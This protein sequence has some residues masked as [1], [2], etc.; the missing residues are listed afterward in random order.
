MFYAAILLCLNL[1]WADRVAKPAQPTLLVDK[2]NRPLPDDP[3]SPEVGWRKILP[4][5]AKTW[6]SV[7]QLVADGS[8]RCT[9]TVIKPPGCKDPS[10]QKA[11]VITNGHCTARAREGFKVKF[12]VIDGLP[13]SHQSE[14]AARP[15]YSTQNHFDL[16]VLELDQDY[17]SLAQFGVSATEIAPSLK[18]GEKVANVAIPL[19]QLP[20]NQQIMRINESCVPD[21]PVTIIDRFRFFDHQVTLKS[22]SLTGGSSGSGLFNTSGQLAGLANAGVINDVPNNSSH[23]CELDT[24]VYDGKSTPKRQMSNFGFDITFLHKC[25]KDC[26]LDTTLPDCPLPDPGRDLG[27][28]GF[29]NANWSSDLNKKVNI[30]SKLFKNYQVKG[31]LPATNCSCKDPSGYQVM[32]EESGKKDMNGS[33]QT[34]LIPSQYFPKETKLTAKAGE[35]P[36]FQFLCLRGQLPNGSWDQLK[37]ATAFP[38]Y[39]YQKKPFSLFK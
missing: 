27:T 20:A 15:L 12:G 30:T 6:S 39:L 24:C 36:T 13:A 17:D 21:K 7:G 10:K 2:E 38:I 37:N 32:K 29:D 5:E 14:I 4:S 18:M 28:F 23:V 9:T 22:C 35:P 31:C 25:Y 16:A 26:R 34:A 3:S 1:A 19:N 8:P 33:Y 11:Q